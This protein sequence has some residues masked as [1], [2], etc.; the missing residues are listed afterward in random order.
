MEIVVTVPG[1]PVSQGRPRFSRFGGPGR[2]QLEHPRAIEP[3]K[4]RSWKRDARAEMLAVRGGGA[5]T[6]PEGPLD[7]HVVAVFSCP[8]GDWRKTEPTP[9][10]AHAK[11]PDA[12]NVAKAALDAAT[13]VIWT[14]DAQVAQLLVEKIIGAQGEAPYVRITVRPWGPR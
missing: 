3:E 7:V 4:S 14:D 11:K 5:L 10:R 13:G 12:E 9:R 6:F 2:P 1:E 8:K